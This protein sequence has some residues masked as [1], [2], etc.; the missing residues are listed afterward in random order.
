MRE[1]RSRGFAAG[2]GLGYLHTATALAA[3]L[4]LTPYLLGRL[5]AHDYGLWLIGAQVLAYLA[6]MDIGIVALVPREVAFAVGQGRG[7]DSPEV[8]ALVGRTLGVVSWQV[9]FVVAAV[10]ATWWW[11]PADWT[12]VRGPLGVALFGFALL[13]PLRVF[14]AL[15]QGLQDLAYLGVAH[16]AGLVVGTLAT[17]GAV[18]GGLGLYALAMG[19]VAGQ[20]VPA[21][22]AWRRLRQHHPHVWPREPISRSWSTVRGQLSRG[23]WISVSQVAQVLMTGTDVLVVGALIG[24]EAVVVY[25]CTGKLLSMLANQPQLLLQTALPALSELRGAAARDRLNQ[26]SRSMTQL[27]FLASG[28]IVVSVLVVNQGFVVWWVGAASFGGLALT[29]VLL[30]SMFVRH[31]NFAAVYTLF[32][33]G[34][35]RRLALTSVADGIVGAVA[36]LVLVPLVGPIGAPIGLLLATVFVSLPAN[37]RALGRETGTAPLAFLSFW[38]GWAVRFVLVLACAAAVALAIEGTVW[39]AAGLAA[40]STLVMYAA[41]MAPELGRPPLGPMLAERIGPW[42]VFGAPWGRPANEHGVAP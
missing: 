4:V 38:S 2:L 31:V 34:H 25:V 13:F 3:A 7:A 9:P 41:V 24:P 19:W 40:A 29:A 14:V 6:L 15:L 22:M 23:V 36:M 26:I 33:F 5:G 10:A 35:E 42:R 30:T 32:C 20:A 37:L 21:A 11:L 18:W 12:L 27:L 17:A 1:G 28:A 8:R 16:L 39:W